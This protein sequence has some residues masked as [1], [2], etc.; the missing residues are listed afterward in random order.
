M[1]EGGKKKNIQE[2]EQHIGQQGHEMAE[3]QEQEQEQEQGYDLFYLYL[4]LSAAKE[5]MLPLVE[6]NQQGYIDIVLEQEQDQMQ[7]G[8][9]MQEQEQEQEQE[10]DQQGLAFFLFALLD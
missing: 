1:E 10:Q 4:Y 7:E 3:E 5:V 2:E 8:D 6:L 9:Q